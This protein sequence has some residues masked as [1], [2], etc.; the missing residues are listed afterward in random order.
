MPKSSCPNG[1]IYTIKAGDTFYR[2]AQRYNLSVQNLI[3]A[4]PN[5]SPRNLQIGQRICIP[6]QLTPTT[7]IL[8]LTPAPDSRTPNA[9]GVL[10]LRRREDTEVELL[11]IG[12]G[13]PS[14]FRLDAERYIA[15]FTWGR[16]TLEVALT[17]IEVDDI[18]NVWIGGTSQSVPIEFF[19]GSVDIVSSPE[20]GPPLI[21]GLIED[22]Q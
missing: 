13:L 4:N 12:V 22:C 16:T 20:F 9:S 5:I 11:V 17:N 1:F 8:R 3:D 2:L 7:C 19:S 6:T 10:W 18:P 21:G 15:N 14:P